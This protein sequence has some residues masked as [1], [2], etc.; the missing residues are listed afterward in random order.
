MRAFLGDYAGDAPGGSV[1]AT[2]GAMG[3]H[4]TAQAPNGAGDGGR[5][6]LRFGAAVTGSV[7]RARP[8]AR[9][10]RQQ[11]RKLRTG[12]LAR[13]Q[14]IGAGVVE[15]FLMGGC[16]LLVFGEVHDPGLAEAGIAFDRAVD[17]APDA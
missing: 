1:E 11:R 8:L 10:A 17:G 4:L 7:E 2:H 16:S 12:Y 6:H 14:L 13:V 3:Q 5:C 15:P 9:S